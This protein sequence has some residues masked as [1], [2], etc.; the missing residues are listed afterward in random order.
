MSTS[1]PVETV[2]F[3]LEVITYGALVVVI[4]A[5]TA[6]LKYFYKLS[7]RDTATNKLRFANRIQYARIMGLLVCLVGM[8]ALHGGVPFEYT[9]LWGIVGASCVRHIDKAFFA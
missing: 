9:L 5:S 7:S 8:I 1:P 4:L 3:T 6:T 2:V